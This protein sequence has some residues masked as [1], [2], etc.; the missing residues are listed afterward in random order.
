MN[1]EFDIELVREQI[2]AEVRRKR[3]SGELPEALERELD[4]DFGR[5]SVTSDQPE[6]TDRNRD[7]V[8]L[9]KRAAGKAI[10]RLTGFRKTR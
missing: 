5:A 7:P 10:R 8:R 3:A 9:V 6:T 1:P 2:D 4:R